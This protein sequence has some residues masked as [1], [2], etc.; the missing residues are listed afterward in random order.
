M[1]SKISEQQIKVMEDLKEGS[2]IHVYRSCAPGMNLRAFMVH[3]KGR[4]HAGNLRISTVMA[5]KKKKII[6]RTEVVYGDDWA[7]TW[8]LC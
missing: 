4:G 7:G 2:A 3:K 6:K 8:K 5:L 1:S